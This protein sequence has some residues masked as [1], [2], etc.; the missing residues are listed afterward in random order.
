M[1]NEK[2][3]RTVGVH[4]N[5]DDKTDVEILEYLQKRAGERGSLS[6]VIKKILF[7]YKEGVARPVAGPPPDPATREDPEP[8]AGEPEKKETMTDEDWQANSGLFG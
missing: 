2:R 8:E 1:A 6:G 3:H 5:L 7:A 4:F